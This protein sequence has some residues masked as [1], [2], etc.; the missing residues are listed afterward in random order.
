MSKKTR[1]NILIGV[2]GGIAAYKT[3]FFIRLLLKKK[4]SVKVIMTEAATKFVTPLTFSAL[5]Q[6]KVHLDMFE[7]VKDEPVKHICLAQW[8]SLCLIAPCSANT[9]SKIALGICDNLL[10]TVVCAL[11]KET[12]VYLAPAMNDCMWSNPLIQDNINKLEK[13]KKYKII[14]PLK[15]ELAC[16]SYGQ[17]RMAEPEEIFKKITSGF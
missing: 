15:G 12:K 8:A 16:G 11:P 6:N 7:E 14:N 9:L 1:K 10:T 4:Y 5:T 3:C 13:I 17:G 2:C